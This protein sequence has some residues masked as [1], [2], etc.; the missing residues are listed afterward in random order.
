MPFHFRHQFY[1]TLKRFIGDGKLDLTSLQTKTVARLCSIIAH[2]E[3]GDFT[4]ERVPKYSS[5]IPLSVYNPYAKMSD[6]QK[7]AAIEHGKLVNVPVSESKI[8]FLHT[9]CN[10]PG[11]GIEVF[12]GK[13]SD[14]KMLKKVDI[15]VGNDGIR[16]YSV[17][18]DYDMKQGKDLLKKVLEKR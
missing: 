12:R 17:Y 10:I 4:H 2:I 1:L 9:T 14:H 7:D 11:Y 6:L 13:L 18:C 8:E 5:Y 15:Y 3:C 16:V